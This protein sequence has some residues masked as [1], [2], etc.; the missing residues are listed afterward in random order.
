MPLDIGK[1][2]N[3]HEKGGKTTAACPACRKEGHDRKGD[4]LVLYPDGR[5]GCVVYEGESAESRAHRK[6]IW[7]MAGNNTGAPRRGS[8][9]LV[10]GVSPVLNPN[11]DKNQ[12]KTVALGRFGRSSI[13]YART[14]AGAQ[15]HVCKSLEQPS[16]PSDNWQNV[17]ETARRLFNAELLPDDGLDADMHDRLAMIENVL[18]QRDSR[19]LISYTRTQIESC[20]IGLRRHAGTHAKIDTMLLR[21]DE[22]KKSALTRHDI[23]GRQ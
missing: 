3:V 14:Q 6:V 1:L 21:L 4:H 8:K 18:A 7:E 12:H 22:A 23:A 19:G 10:L 20:A 2:E 16:E 17:I 13:T 15:A 5:F 11:I 9:N